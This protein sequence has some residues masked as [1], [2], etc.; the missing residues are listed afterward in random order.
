MLKDTNVLEG[1]ASSIFRVV[2]L[3]SVGKGGAFTH[4]EI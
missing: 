2:T 4:Q 3:F 1:V